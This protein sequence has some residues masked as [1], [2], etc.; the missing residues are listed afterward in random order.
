MGASWGVREG[1]RGAYLA[2]SR[3]FFLT[4]LSQNPKGMGD[5]FLL[6]KSTELRHSTML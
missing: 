5:F 6:Y 1:W 2:T 4:S 3:L